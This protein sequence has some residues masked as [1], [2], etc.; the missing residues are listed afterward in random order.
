MDACVFY[1]GSYNIECGWDDLGGVALA[2]KILL[3]Q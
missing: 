3:L 2:R 1:S